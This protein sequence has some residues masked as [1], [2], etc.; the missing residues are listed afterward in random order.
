ML[1]ESDFTIQNSTLLNA[2]THLLLAVSG[3]IDSVVLCHLVH[4]TG[5]PFEMAHC[6]F[7]LRGA[8]SDRDEAFVRRLAERYAVK[9]HVAQ[10]DTRAYAAERHLSIE[11][12]ARQLRYQFFASCVAGHDDARVLTAHHRDDAAETFF[13]NLLRGT[14]IAGLVGMRPLSYLNCTDPPIVVA[15][16]LL[17]FSR[18]EIVSYADAQGLEHVEDVTNQSL[19]YRRNRVRHEV[20]PLLRDMVPAADKSI[21]ET[22]RHLADTEEIYRQSIEAMR[23]RVVQRQAA[24]DRLDIDALRALHPLRTWLFELLRPYGFNA[25]QTDDIRRSL[26]GASG[27]CFYSATHRLVR[28]RDSLFV[29]PLAQTDTEAAPAHTMETLSREAYWQRFGT[30]RTTAAQALFDAD[31]LPLPLRWRHVR[32]ADRFHPFGMKGSRLVSDL[33]SDQKLAKHEREHWWLLCD[34]EDTV[35]WVSGLRADGRYAVSDTTQRVLLVS[36]L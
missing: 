33:F 10:F 21:A 2:S 1:T 17:P 23:Q 14:G 35:L 3:G 13:L 27:H 20:L 22:L 4:A 18:E 19:D 7:H 30:W 32:A 15:H 11:E 8:D 26:D 6:N 9:C 34:A 29:S 28:E 24:G 25:A 36:L 12:A 5:R 31:R 16:P